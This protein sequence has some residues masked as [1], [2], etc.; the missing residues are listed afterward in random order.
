MGNRHKTG[1]EA[2]LQLEGVHRS[3]W[4][5]T[6]ILLTKTKPP[7]IYFKEAKMPEGTKSVFTGMH[8]RILDEQDYRGRKLVPKICL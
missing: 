5:L 1:A 2:E 6:H 8:N 3:W 7:Q 4:K